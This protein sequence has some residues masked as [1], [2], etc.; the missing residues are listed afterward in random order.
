MPKNLEV[1]SAI[2]NLKI[3]VGGIRLHALYDVHGQPDPIFLKGK[4]TP[5]EMQVEVDLRT[6]RMDLSRG[7]TEA[8][9]RSQILRGNQ[10]EGALPI[11]S[12][13]SGFA[14]HVLDSVV[15]QE[16]GKPLA[17]FFEIPSAEVMAAA[18]PWEHINPLKPDQ[19]EHLETNET[20]LLSWDCERTGR[21]PASQVNVGRLN[22]DSA[23]TLV[24]DLDDI[25]PGDLFMLHA[26]ER[27]THMGLVAA[28]NGEEVQIWDAGRSHRSAIDTLGGIGPHDVTIDALRGPVNA[29]PWSTPLGE[30]FTA[31]TV[32][33]LHALR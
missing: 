22:N 15:M 20:V 14:Y 18:Q 1:L 29:I 17:E 25:Q 6:A 13:C 26:G 19:R 2:D 7:V 8:G 27:P 10:Q 4:A 11:S 33:R 24:P 16:R 31:A 32:R 30:Q 9:I 3:T 28:R 5:A 23:S 21:T 12:D